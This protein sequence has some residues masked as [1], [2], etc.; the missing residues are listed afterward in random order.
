MED[1]EKKKARF[2]VLRLTSDNPDL[3]EAAILPCDRGPNESMNLEFDFYGIKVKVTCENSTVMNSLRRDYEYFVSEG[4]DDSAHLYLEALEQPPPY[5]LIPQGTEASSI[6][7]FCT[8]YRKDDHVYTDYQGRGFLILDLE[9]ENGKIYSTNDSFLTTLLRR[10]ILTRVSDL[11]SA[12]GIYKFSWL[13]MSVNGLAIIFSMLPG[14][15]KTSLALELLKTSEFKILSDTYTFITRTGEILP[16]PRNLHP[17]GGMVSE[18]PQDRQQLF[19]N[20]RYEPRVMIDIDHFRDQL[21]SSC[22]PFLLAVCKRIFSEEPRIEKLPKWRSFLLLYRQALVKYEL[23]ESINDQETSEK[24]KSR[25]RKH[26]TSAKR[27]LIV[28]KLLYKSETY[29]FY[30][31][32]NNSRNAKAINTFMREKIQQKDRNEATPELHI[33]PHN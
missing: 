17:R 27:A 20:T 1:P 18:I 31:G 32:V 8:S 19:D 9:G 23:Y 7:M 21:S 4:S 22:K 26:L 5:H 10:T 24:E 13:S 11:L 6:S 15:G 29:L 33:S 2:D 28:I 14:G 25:F 30:L 12:K 3:S 16:F